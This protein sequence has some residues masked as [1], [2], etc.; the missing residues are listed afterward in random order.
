MLTAIGAYVVAALIPSP[1]HNHAGI[2]IA[3]K[4]MQTMSKALGLCI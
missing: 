1:V 3:R 2:M 4:E